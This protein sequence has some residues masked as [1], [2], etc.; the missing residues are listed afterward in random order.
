[1]LFMRRLTLDNL[2]EQTTLSSVRDARYGDPFPAANAL[3]IVEARV[4]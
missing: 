1:M 4:G 2:W 3:A